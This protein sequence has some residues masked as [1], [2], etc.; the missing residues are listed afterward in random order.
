MYIW[1]LMSYLV[2]F[3]NDGVR[4]VI[5]MSIFFVVVVHFEMHNT[6]LWRKKTGFL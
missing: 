3:T 6:A 4:E 2:R 5:I 1:V